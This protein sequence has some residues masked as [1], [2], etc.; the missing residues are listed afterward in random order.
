MNK[1]SQTRRRVMQVIGLAGAAA[2]LPASAQIL[3]AKITRP[4]KWEIPTI[5]EV[6]SGICRS[7]GDSDYW[8]S[9]A[10]TM[11]SVMWPALE[12][13]ARKQEHVVTYDLFSEMA[14]LKNLE[15]FGIENANTEEGKRV[16]KYLGYLPYYVQ[17]EELPEQS[18]MQHGYLV[19]QTSRIVQKHCGIE[20]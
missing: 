19:M 6:V 1:V 17:G 9:M 13:E 5:E 2:V 11:V 3:N 15:K 14:Y 7:A 12:I 8:Q 16:Q 20:T 4:V 18:L 10:T